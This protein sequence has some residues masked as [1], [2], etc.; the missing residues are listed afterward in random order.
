MVS[1]IIGTTFLFFG[2]FCLGV[3]CE[4]WTQQIV[5]QQRQVAMWRRQQRIKDLIVPL[6]KN[7]GE[8]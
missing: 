7:W 3:W 6:P 1:L 8:G 5:E 4:R 2:G